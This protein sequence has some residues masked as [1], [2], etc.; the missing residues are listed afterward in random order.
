MSFR[1]AVV[2]HAV[3]RAVPS[4][5]ISLSLAFRGKASSWIDSNHRKSRNRCNQTPADK[6]WQIPPPPQWPSVSQDLIKGVIKSVEQNTNECFFL[7]RVITRK[8]TKCDGGLNMSLK[9]AVETNRVLSM[10]LL[11]LL[12][13]KKKKKSWPCLGLNNNTQASSCGLHA[14]NICYSNFATIRGC[15]HWD[16]VSNTVPWAL[17]SFCI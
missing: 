4:S 14:G 15:V 8:N 12:T 16:P 2:C 10:P 7:I 5:E 3:I 13:K 1:G 11:L 9:W 6:Q 17:N